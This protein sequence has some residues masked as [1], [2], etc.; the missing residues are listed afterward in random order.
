MLARGYRDPCVGGERAT[1]GWSQG[2]V[3]HTDA[4][5]QGPWV[6]ASALSAAV[7]PVL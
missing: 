4:G 1:V 7:A 5:R 3:S 6:P 2:W